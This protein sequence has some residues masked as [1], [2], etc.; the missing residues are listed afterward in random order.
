M[1]TAVVVRT[2]VYAEV[3]FRVG[4]KTIVTDLYFLSSL[5]KM[6]NANVFADYDANNMYI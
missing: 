6:W 1:W 2:C 5:L 3:F 4:T